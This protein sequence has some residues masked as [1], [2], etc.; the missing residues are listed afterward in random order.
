MAEVTEGSIHGITGMGFEHDDKIYT[1]NNSWRCILTKK[2]C[3]PCGVAVSSKSVILNITAPPSAAL[4]LVTKAGNFHV[5][6]DELCLGK[7]MARYDGHFQIELAPRDF[8]LSKNNAEDDSPCMAMDK[9]GRIWTCWVSYENEKDR[10]LIKKY[11]NETWSDEIEVTTKPGIYYKPVVAAD[12]RKGIWVIWSAFENRNWDLLARNYHGS[13]WSGIQRLTKD[14]SNDTNPKIATDPSGTIWL[15]WESYR[16]GN[17]DIFMKY[18]S[19]NRWS[20]DIQVTKNQDNDRQPDLAVDNQGKPY[21][22]WTRFTNGR[23]QVLLKEGD[24]ERETER[25]IAVSQNPLANPDIACNQDGVW[26][27]WDEIKNTRS[28]LSEE[29]DLSEKTDLKEFFYARRSITL[30]CYK[31][32]FV[33]EPAT[34]F[35]RDLPFPLRQ[36][37]ELPH[38]FIDDK[39][40]LCVF[41]HNYVASP[42]HG[43]WRIYGMYYQGNE[44][45]QPILLPH[46]TWKNVA[47]VSTCGDDSGNVWVAWGSD[48]R[49][50]GSNFLSD[51]DIFVGCMSLR[52]KAGSFVSL[53]PCN[54]EEEI[55]TG[56]IPLRNKQGINGRSKIEGR[57]Y[58]LVWGTLYQPNDVKGYFGLDGFVMDIYRTVMDESGLNFLGIGNSAKFERGNYSR[59]QARKA[60]CLFSQADQFIA[61]TIPPDFQNQIYKSI[62]DMATH[63]EPAIMGALVKDLSPA[64][65]QEALDKK[66]VYMATDKIILEARILGNPLGD[67]MNTREAT[68]KIEVMVEG[69]EELYQVDILRNGACIYTRFPRGKE[70]RFTFLDL[71]MPRGTN[72]YVIQVLQKNGQAARTLPSVINAR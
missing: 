14:S 59:W 29:S 57:D 17:A 36:H 13:R 20:D 11:E 38:L 53:K 15:C 68:S 51:R 72:Q 26:I 43:I 5:P 22:T 25:E 30:R 19:D 4:V 40:R 47:S 62:E 50:I 61:V 7:T 27:A 39:K 70:S 64:S 24:L 54:Y 34:D 28:D 69:T 37:A 66:R 58:K 45:S 8:L 55:D 21:I 33:F 52:N 65:M 48:N 71:K 46:Y 2:P 56:Q 41:F 49:D 44:W 67:T 32:G 3:G 6:V 12:S 9:S 10:I 63:Q 35:Y 60:N 42:P 16:Q 1:P 23:Y 18:F 31:N